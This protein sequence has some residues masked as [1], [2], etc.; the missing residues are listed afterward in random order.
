VQIGEPERFSLQALSMFAQGS[1]LGISTSVPAACNALAE[2]RKEGGAASQPH[3]A[4]AGRL[5]HCSGVL[6][7]WTHP[8]CR[9]L[10]SG[11]D[12]RTRDRKSPAVYT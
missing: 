11:G 7:L 4:L 6:D 8:Q 10:N 3:G 12:C 9:W 1:A 2:A 5:G